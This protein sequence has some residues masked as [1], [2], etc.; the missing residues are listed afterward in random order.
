MG[1]WKIDPG[2]GMPLKEGHSAL[3]RP[4]EF[5][6][7]NAV[8]GVDSEEGAFYLGDSP[9]DL[10]STI[11]REIEGV[12]GTARSL[13]DEGVRDLLLRRVVPRSVVEWRP[14]AAARLL[15]VVDAFWKDIDDIYAEDWG[16]PSRPAERRWICEYLLECRREHGA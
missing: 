9:W 12:I 14:E 13:S 10:V 2:T 3:S 5:V 11:P 4:P 7:L 15:Q 8:P 6:L 1:W 16:R